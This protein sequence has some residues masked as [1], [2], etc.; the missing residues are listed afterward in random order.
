MG[1]RSRRDPE[2]H[3][4]RGKGHPTAMRPPAARGTPAVR[5][6]REEDR[7]ELDPTRQP[8]LLPLEPHPAFE[9]DEI[10]LP[11]GRTRT[12]ATTGMNCLRAATTTVLDVPYDEVPAGWER[13]GAGMNRPEVPY[14]MLVEWCEWAE[15]RGYVPCIHT[16]IHPSPTDRPWWAAIV[17][18]V[19]G[20]GVHFNIYVMRHGQVAHSTLVEWRGAPTGPWYGLTVDREHR[21][22]FPLREHL[23]RFTPEEFMWPLLLEAHR[24][25]RGIPIADAQRL[26]SADG[27]A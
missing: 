1:K 17:L 7:A 8:Y 22:G 27:R 24:I 25:D 26:D 20:L 14:R 4:R 13:G 15:A 10:E 16:A 21:T 9:N 11:D 2:G 12:Y 19:Q 6:P 3:G 18:R 5:I 23:A